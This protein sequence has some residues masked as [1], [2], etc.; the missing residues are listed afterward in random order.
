MAGKAVL[1]D[2]SRCIG[3]RGCQVACKQ[4]NELPA[5]QTKNRGSYQN[6]P[7][8]SAITY[9]VVRFKELS[10]NGT[11]KWHFLKDQCRHC[12]EPP[13]EAVT[14]EVPGSAA[15]DANGAVVYTEKTAKITENLAESCPYNIPRKDE[16]TGQWTKCT[17]CADRIAEGME[18]ACVK[19][20]PT[21]ALTFG[22]HEEIVA[23]G[24]KRLDALKAT[25][26]NAKLLDAED[27]RWIYLLHE[28][29]EEFQM[30]MRRDV[31]PYRFSLGKLLRPS[32]PVWA[33]AGSLG[34]ILAKRGRGVAETEPEETEQSG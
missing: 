19:A 34:L 4:W 33:L 15:R 14:G 23:L 11:I 18:P 8:L 16:K 26:P 22:D 32:F 31:S 9:T 24:K 7:G 1:V 25:H 13:C 20:C 27:V 6:P 29:E 30:S 10:Q 2:V 5:E 28:R 12:V 21:G 3:C 17:F